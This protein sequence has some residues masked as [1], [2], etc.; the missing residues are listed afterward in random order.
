MPAAVPGATVIRPV[1]GS[2]VSSGA[3]APTVNVTS[4]G[5]TARPFN[6]SEARTDVVTPPSAPLIAGKF[7]IATAMAD[8]PTTTVSVTVAQLSGFRFSQIVYSTV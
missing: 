7:S 2:R 5:L 4:A 3:E 1:A 6:L 8:S